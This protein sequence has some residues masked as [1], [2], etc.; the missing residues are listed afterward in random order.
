MS[1]IIS[2]K[3]TILALSRG[4]HHHYAPLESVDAWRVI[5]SPE[6]CAETLR[7]IMPD[8]LITPSCDWYESAACIKEAR[9]LNI[10]SL[11]IMDGII[12]WRHQWENP[13]FG[14]GGGM[15][16]N[17]PIIT[18][19]I[20]CLGWQSART[21]EGWGC[22]GKCEL[23]GVPRFDHYIL[24]PVVRTPHDGPKRLLIMTANT[25]GFTP[26]QI[27]LTEQSLLDVN[28]YIQKHPEWEPIWRVRKG[29]DT[30]L[31]LVDRFPDLRGKPLR[32]VLAEADAVLSTPSTVLLEAMLA[33]LPTAILDY[34][35]SPTYVP[36]AWMVTAPQHI[37]FVLDDLRYSPTRRL[38]FQ[39]DILHNCLVCH[40]PALPRMQE[41]VNVMVEIGRQARAKGQQLTYPDRILPLDSSDHM[42]PTENFDLA[43]LYP[44]HPIFTNQNMI[45]L[46]QELMYAHQEVARLRKEVASR[47]FGYFARAALSRLSRFFN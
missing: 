45:S 2:E 32:E 35:N 24:D 39:D 14:A 33:G 5:E 37:A 27:T 46:Q 21:L 34:S 13:R 8:I 20:A 25:P 29:L 12:E 4:Q 7:D 1:Q 26:E 31:S 6:W 15:P 23:V 28:E 18:D 11:Y 19:K 44:S 3:T 40:D 30:K 42:V 22:I 43:R 38:L 47:R 9:R 16:Y 10:P 41:L 17:Q 36:A